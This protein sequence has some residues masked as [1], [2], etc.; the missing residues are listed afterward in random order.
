M[1]RVNVE[2]PAASHGAHSRQVQGNSADSGESVDVVRRTEESSWR[3]HLV[4][5][6][7]VKRPAASSERWQGGPC[8]GSF[9]NKVSPSG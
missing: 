8:I 4:V 7:F 3:S 2:E 5:M 9:G 1:T 6:Q